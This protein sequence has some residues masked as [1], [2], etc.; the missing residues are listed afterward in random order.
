M[1]WLFVEPCSRRFASQVIGCKN[2]FDFAVP[3]KPNFL[4]VPIRVNPHADEKYRIVRRLVVSLTIEVYPDTFS[5]SE[6]PS[7]YTSHAFL[8]TLA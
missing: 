7:R 5:A 4:P 3:V 6:V 1:I 2:I 8:E